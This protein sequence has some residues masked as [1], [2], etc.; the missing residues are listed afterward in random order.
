MRCYCAIYPE[1][2]DTLA[3]KLMYFVHSPQGHSQGIK[4]MAMLDGS[5][6]KQI[7]IVMDIFDGPSE[8]K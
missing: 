5:I 4:L 7:H 2:Q 6:E 3:S 8:Q 1:A